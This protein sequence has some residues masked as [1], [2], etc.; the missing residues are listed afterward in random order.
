MACIYT[1]EQA[2]SFPRTREPHFRRVTQSCNGA[3]HAEW[4]SRVREGDDTG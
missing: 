3:D 1:D 2:P 4:G